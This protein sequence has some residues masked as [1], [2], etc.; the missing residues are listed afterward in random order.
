MR[1]NVKEN[2]VLLRQYL[3]SQWRKPLS[4]TAY[5][6]GGKCIIW[7]LLARCHDALMTSLKHHKTPYQ[8]LSDWLVGGVYTLSIIWQHIPALYTSQRHIPALIKEGEMETY[9]G[10]SWY[11]AVGH[12]TC[13]VVGFGRNRV[14]KNALEKVFFICRIWWFPV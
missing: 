7:L 1:E 10:T 3:N 13:T 4:S 11:A 2:A 6:M 5:N 14:N 9:C 8:S 12:R